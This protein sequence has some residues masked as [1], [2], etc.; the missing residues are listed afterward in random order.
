MIGVIRTITEIKERIAEIKHRFTYK[1]EQ[2]SSVSNK[3]ETTPSSSFS[4]VLSSKQKTTAALNSRIK[5]VIEAAAQKYNLTPELLSSII[6]VESNFD[7]NAK[8]PAGARGLMQL[9]P[10]TSK[11][12]GVKN[13][14]DPAENVM[15]GAKYFSSMLG[16]Y[17]GDIKLALSA[18]NAGPGRVDERK[19]IPDI[20]ETKKYVEKVLKEYYG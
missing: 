4:D 2:K 3:H 9:M 13:S 18:Y 6:K 11:S 15:A 8:S 20:D 19:G 1:P 16:K 14:F 12:L 7:P 10:E 17:N 5:P